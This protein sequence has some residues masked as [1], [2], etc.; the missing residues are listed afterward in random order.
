MGLLLRKRFATRPVSHAAGARRILILP[1]YPQY[2]ATTTASV[3]DAV[4]AAIAKRRWVP[5]LRLINHFHDE[6]GYI[7]A[8]SASIAEYWQQ[9]DKG[10][11]LL[12]SF[13]GLPKKNLENGDPYH[14]HCLKTAR[15]IAE[16]LQLTDDSWSVAFQSRVGREEWLQPYTEDVLADFGKEKMRRVD[17][18]CPGFSVDCL[19]TLEEIDIRYSE[20]FVESGG[21]SL[22]YIPC[23]N[24]R[25]DHVDFLADLVRQHVRG[26]P[27]SIA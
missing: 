22:N 13:H 16:S 3:F 5:E 11:H 25:D 9:N 7:S 23:L 17:V 27:E 20:V 21:G 15:L 8:A 12:F 18:V 24:D 4:F 1:L 2:S 19:E 26:W 14:C 10:D 6:P